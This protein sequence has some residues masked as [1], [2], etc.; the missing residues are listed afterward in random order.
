MSFFDKNDVVEMAVKMERNG[1]KFY[2]EGLK[3]NDLDDM[4]KELIKKLRDDEVS[5]E[6]TFLSLR[7]KLDDYDIRNEK[8]WDEIEFYADT[9]VGT[10]VFSKPDS[11]IK[12]ANKAKN[13]KEL[14]EY[15][16]KFE[17][18]TLLFFHSIRKYVKN[19]KAI[20]AVD[21]IINEEILHVEQ[22]NNILTKI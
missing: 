17:K 9:L 14:F 13:G 2:D 4:Q 21:K 7:N 15:A 8:N 16:V 20:D 19:K 1:F 5:H 12:L 18:D 10:H 11:A 22:L 6:K 3:R